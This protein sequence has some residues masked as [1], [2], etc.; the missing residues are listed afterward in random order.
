MA[1]TPLPSPTP[2]GVAGVACAEIGSLGGALWSARPP[3][4]LVEG[5]EALQQL[6]ASVSA[7][8]AQLVAELDVREVPRRELGWGST[9]DWYSHTAGTTRRQ[10]KRAVV[11]ARALVGDR[12][13][14]LA[15]LADGRVSPD[16][17]SRS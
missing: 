13:A 12:T 6:K 2:A 4:E 17:A 9:A 10:G 5:V 16:Q 3:T 15:A 14:T 11:H 7:L 8:E 1:I